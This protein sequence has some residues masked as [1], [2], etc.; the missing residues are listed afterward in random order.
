MESIAFDNGEKPKEGHLEEEDP[1]ASFMEGYSNEDEV[2]ECAECGGAVNEEKKIVRDV[3]GEKYVF[4]SE[5]C[6]NEFM[7]ST[8]SS[9]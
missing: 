2:E 6:A 1:V 4:C 5:I 3:E 7:E 9:S 8:S